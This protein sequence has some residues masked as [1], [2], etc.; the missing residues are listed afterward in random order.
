MIPVPYSLL[1]LHLQRLGPLVV[2][3]DAALSFYPPPVHACPL[4]ELQAAVER[5]RAVSEEEDGSWGEMQPGR[6]W[7]WGHADVG[8]PY[9]LGAASAITSPKQ[10]LQHLFKDGMGHL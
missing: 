7:S 9:R 10:F 5:A 6:G 1:L 8:T 2:L 3:V 4:V